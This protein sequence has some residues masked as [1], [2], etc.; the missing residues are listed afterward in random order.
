MR[1]AVHNPYD[2]MIPFLWVAALAFVTG[3][4]GYVGLHGLPL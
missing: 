3:F 4:L 2:V 1:T